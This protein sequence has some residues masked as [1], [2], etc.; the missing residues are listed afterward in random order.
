MQNFHVSWR[1][2]QW[3]SEEGVTTRH[4][5]W[6]FLSIVIYLITWVANGELLQGITNGSVGIRVYDK[7]AAVTWFSYNFMI[8]SSILVALHAHNQ[9]LNW[10]RVVQKWA[11]NFG[12]RRAIS[13]CA[14]TSY[15]LLLLNI[16]MIVGLRCVSVSLSNAIYQL[17]TPF[18]IALS[19]FMLGDSFVESEA[20]GILLSFTGVCLIVIPPLWEEGGQF[21]WRGILATAASAA[22]G[23]VYLISWRVLERKNESPLNRWESF[24]D[25]QMTLAAI[26]FCNLL[27]GW[28]ILPILDGL[29]FEM[30]ELPQD[31]GI[32]CIN[33]LVEYA[34]DASCAIAIFATSPVM[35]AIVAPLTIPLSMFMDQLLY[36]GSEVKEWSI[37]S[38]IVLILLGTLMMELKPI[39]FKRKVKEKDEKEPFIL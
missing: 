26:G 33:G 37:W 8:L 27:V 1:G 14:A 21:C 30:M 34:F 25:M 2:F 29:K 22:I 19:V 4:S 5:L 35:V 31:W 36:G 39:I 20:I 7:P 10:S 3:K 13:V 15:L 24:I 32:L 18:T 11:G 38:G 9:K 28:P 17:Q 6:K 16:L 12:V 23:G